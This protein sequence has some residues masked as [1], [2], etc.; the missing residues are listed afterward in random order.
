MAAENIT[1]TWQQHARSASRLLLE[2]DFNASQQEYR[3][4]ISAAHDQNVSP[5]TVIDLQLNLAHAQVLNL[6]IE[7]A[8][9][10]LKFT[11]L[12]VIQHDLS[13]SIVALHYWRRVRQLRRA[14][15][16]F[17]ESTLAGQKVL[18]EMSKHFDPGT[19]AF[20]TEMA[21]LEDDAIRARQW[22][23]AVKAANSINDYWQKRTG[24]AMP[25]QSKND[26]QWLQNEISPAFENACNQNAQQKSA[27]LIK[28][29][30]QIPGTNDE[31]FRMWGM[32]AQVRSVS[33]PVADDAFSKAKSYY[34][35]LDAAQQH[36]SD[37]ELLAASVAHFWRHLGTHQ[38]DPDL[39]QTIRTILRI[40]LPVETSA[41]AILHLQIVG[42]YTQMLAK[43]RRL[44]EAER[45]AAQLV[46]KRGIIT[47]VTDLDGPVMA[48]F[49]LARQFAK[50]GNWPKA[51]AQI[52][53]LETLLST[54][55]NVP[56]QKNLRSAWKSTAVGIVGNH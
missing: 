17:A 52:D 49:E 28:L 44:S 46:A 39:E 48:R 34:A 30:G 51:H 56:N 50:K 22:E 32:A 45:V 37:R 20:Q 42:T 11:N 4:A 15:K 47:K 10:T 5:A 53:A 25:P 16:N 6:D 14:Q 9:K 21:Q 3:K 7:D 35:R 38:L 8:E 43:E 24:T 55:P 12:E 18:D 33:T 54:Q 31:L 27:A 26:R 1:T 23:L 40:G 13:N 36:A 41:G 2:N 29:M 19:Q